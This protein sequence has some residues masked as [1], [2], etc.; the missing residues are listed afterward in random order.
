[1]TLATSVNVCHRRTYHHLERLVYVHMVNKTTTQREKQR[2][3][4]QSK[5]DKAKNSWNGANPLS[6]L[7]LM[8]LLS[9]NSSQQSKILP[10]PKA[11]PGA[12]KN[13]SGGQS[14]GTVALGRQLRWKLYSAEPTRAHECITFKMFNFTPL[15]TTGS[16]GDKDFENGL[17]NQDTIFYAFPFF[18]A[19]NLMVAST[20]N[21]TANLPETMN[22]GFNSA[23]SA[24]ATGN[25]GTYKVSPDPNKFGT[26]PTDTRY[27]VSHAY[28]TIRV[29]ADKQVGG[30]LIMKHG[31]QR[32]LGTS[33]STLVPQLR[34]ERHSTKR[35]DL[36]GGWQKTFSFPLLDPEV[37]GN[38]QSNLPTTYV[39]PEQDLTL[40]PMNALGPLV[41][42]FEGVSYSAYVTPPS[43]HVCVVMVLEEEL[44]MSLDDL[45][46]NTPQKGV[47]K[48]RTDLEQQSGLKSEQNTS[49]DTTKSHGGHKSNFDSRGKIRPKK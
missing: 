4:L 17:I 23:Y 35:F 12:R 33:I 8:G 49:G 6:L 46:C 45:A 2:R 20:S 26:G 14:S 15:S 1:M 22:S 44:D 19:T 3:L 47:A 5:S 40:A 7:P 27:R 32:V 42:C 11:K 38:F 10:K 25:L 36:S 28:L 21:T 41:F 37:Y 43:V 30:Q 13:K 18:R 16:Y 39:Y 31:S 9:Q 48:A 29:V 24:T 34:A